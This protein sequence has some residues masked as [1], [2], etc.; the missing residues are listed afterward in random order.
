MR[1]IRR[2]IVAGAML[3]ATAAL[4][5]APA[6]AGLVQADGDGGPV[7]APTISELD[8]RLGLTGDSPLTHVAAPEPEGLTGD[9]A[10]TR[11]GGPVMASQ[12]VADQQ[13]WTWVEV[14]SGTGVVPLR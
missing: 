13:R 11:A 4:A 14:G 3:V 10:L 1:G 8:S 9:S 12:T 6:G 2:T 5:A 7:T